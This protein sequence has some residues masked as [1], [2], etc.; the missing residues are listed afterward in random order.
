M[1]MIIFLFN[2][3]IK[4]QQAQLP[5]RAAGLTFRVLLAFFPFL[6]FLM[7]LLGFLELDE[8]AILSGLY[9]VLPMDI[10]VL[11]T[12]FLSELGAIR[13]G[14]VLSAALFFSVYNTT[15]GFR[16]IIMY[17]NLSYGI[18]DRRNFP[19]QVILSFLLM[20]MFSVALVVMLGLL[21][22]GRQIWA[23]ILPYAADAAIPDALFRLASGAGAAGVL[24]SATFIMYKLACAR[25]LPIRHVLPGAVLAVAGWLI[26]SGLF[27]WVITNFTQYPAVYGSIA[28]VFILILW[29][30]LICFI[31]LIGNEM[32]ALLREYFPV[33]AN[34]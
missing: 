32:N 8:P 24:L 11:A 29:L 18:E 13:S 17:A 34:V 14:G 20:I 7:A 21:V 25:K 26:A 5:E 12:D 1:K 30:N 6:V 16:A 15:N 33:D 27:G 4:C 28:G 9:Q 2:L 23:F 10:A 3:I 22:F 19:L 31:L